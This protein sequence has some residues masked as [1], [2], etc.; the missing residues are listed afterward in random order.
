MM[1]LK[2]KKKKQMIVY[3]KLLISTKYKGKGKTRYI[4]LKNMR[5]MV[6]NKKEEMEI[7]VLKKIRKIKHFLDTIAHNEI[8]QISG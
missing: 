7:F 8:K 4:N 5:C 2:Q 6:N 3:S 1:S